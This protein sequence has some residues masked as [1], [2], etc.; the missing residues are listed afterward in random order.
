MGH[1]RAQG[2]VRV[3]DVGLEFG[4]AGFGMPGDA[5]EPEEKRIPMNEGDDFERDKGALEGLPSERGGG[6]GDPS[7]G[8]RGGQHPF[9]V[10]EIIDSEVQVLSWDHEVEA[11]AGGQIKER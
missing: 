8:E 1:A 3:K 9:S 7:T 10:D 2:R 6:E 4:Q 5:F 11:E